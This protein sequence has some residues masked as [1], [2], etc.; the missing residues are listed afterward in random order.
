MLS[1][2]PSSLRATLYIYSHKHNRKGLR[3]SDTM[4]KNHNTLDQKFAHWDPGQIQNSLK[5]KAKFMPA[6][7]SWV[8]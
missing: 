3:A 7:L 6:W 5:L 8:C 4:S 1:S 2:S